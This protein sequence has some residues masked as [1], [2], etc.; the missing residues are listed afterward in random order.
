M[1][2]KVIRIF[3]N[4]ID[5]TSSSND[6][7]FL[8]LPG[9]SHVLH[10]IPNSRLFH[11]R[12]TRWSPTNL[13]QTQVSLMQGNAN[14]SCFTQVCYCYSDHNLWTSCSR[15]NAQ[16]ST[17]LLMLINSSLFLKSTHSVQMYDLW[18]LDQAETSESDEI[19]SK[20]K[21]ANLW[22][23][24]GETNQGFVWSHSKY[25]PIKQKQSR[26]WWPSWKT[27]DEQLNI[28]IFTLFYVFT[29]IPRIPSW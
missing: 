4:F 1:L 13:N 25:W 19:S 3:L 23:Q 15:P 10:V 27:V 14:R 5:I 17:I 29:N 9:L 21:F 20:C 6:Y 24:T 11:S 12:F 7:S 8:I 2:L 18:W 16:S 26:F 22:V 28:M